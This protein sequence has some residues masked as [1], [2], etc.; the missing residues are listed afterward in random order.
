MC[1]KKKK[2]PMKSL[3]IG[4]F[5]VRMFLTTNSISLIDLGIFK[6][7]YRL[8]VVCIFQRIGPFYQNCQI[9]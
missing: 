1:K 3:G 2:S 6:S 8:L 9:Y 7:Y 4:I 5:S